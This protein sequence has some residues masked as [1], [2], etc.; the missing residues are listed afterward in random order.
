MVNPPSDPLK[1]MDGIAH[2][3]QDIQS[4]RLA[5]RS[6]LESAVEWMS[7]P[8]AAVWCL[9]KYKQHA[10]EQLVRVGSD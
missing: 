9:P 1:L 10:N 2:P 5:Y 8:F 4:V 7:A 3:L 6:R